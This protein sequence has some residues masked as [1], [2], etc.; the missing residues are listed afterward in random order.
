MCSFILIL[1]GLLSYW[2]FHLGEWEGGLFFSV[3]FCRKIQANFLKETV[4][5]KATG[6]GA[7]LNSHSYHSRL[8]AAV[9]D[10][11]E[12]PRRASKKHHR[13]RTKRSNVPHPLCR[14]K[15]LL[16][17]YRGRFLCFNSLSRTNR[18]SPLNTGLMS[19]ARTPLLW[20]WSMV[21][22]PPWPV[23]RI[24]GI[25]SLTRRSCPVSSVPLSAGMISSTITASN[26]FGFLVKR[27]RAS[28]GSLQMTDR[29]PECLSIS[30]SISVITLLSSA[31]RTRY[32]QRPFSTALL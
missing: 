13:E 6:A 19:V 4:G 18:S 15:L 1:S 12:D 5:V 7:S 29:Y 30:A 21:K 31:T 14:R 8:V 10:R 20:I 9:L 3:G 25:W 27:V 11:T 2:P 16:P 22:R 26:L 23:R 24:T 28:R 17:Q 32:L